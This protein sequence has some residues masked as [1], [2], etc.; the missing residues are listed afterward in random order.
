MPMDSSAAISSPAK[1]ATDDW[2]GAA[3]VP[4][5]AFLM[6]VGFI[7][8]DSVSQYEN[9]LQQAQETLDA[10][11]RIAD[12]AISGPVQQI[13]VE[14]N[15]IRSRRLTTQVRDLPALSTE[16]E[17]QQHFLP[18][19]LA[20][21][22][23][24]EQGI[25]DAHTTTSVIGFDAREREHFKVH[26]ARQGAID[27]LHF[28]QPFVS[29]IGTPVVTVSRPII[30][31]NGKFRGVVAAAISMQHL[32]SLVAPAQP[33]GHS[34]LAVTGRSG[35]MYIHLPYQ[36]ALLGKPVSTLHEE[37]PQFTTKR[38]LASVD[39]DIHVG[40]AREEV[41]Q[42]WYTHAYARLITLLIFAGFLAVLIRH[43]VT[44]RREHQRANARFEA[45][46]NHSSD[47]IVIVGRDGIVRYISPSALTI[48]GFE[49]DFAIG[50]H[51][52]DLSHRNDHAVIDAAWK[53]L[54]ATPNATGRIRYRSR[55]MT[56]GWIMV[57]ASAAA[58]FDTPGIEGVLLMLR[59]VSQQI[60]AERQLQKSEAI[61][62][63]AQAVARIG[64][65]SFDIT[66]NTLRGSD[67]ACH[68]LGVA[69]G[70]IF[71]QESYQLCI[72][73]DD[74][75]MVAHE[76]GEALKG[77]TYD[78]GYRIQVGDEILW[79][80]AKADMLRDE[81]GQ[82][83]DCIGTLQ[84]VT[85]QHEAAVQLTEL[86]EFN[87]KVIAESPVGI[88]VYR[89]DG[90]CILANEALARMIGGDLQTVSQQNFRRLAAWRTLGLLDAAMEALHSGGAV[91]CVA[92]GQSS[93]G[94][95]IA[96]DCEFTCIN[97]HGEK[98]LLQLAYDTSEFHA[99]EQ[100]M[101]EAMNF[102]EEA[103]RAKSEF[104]ANMSHEI[105][106]PMNAILGLAQLAIDEA[107]DPRLIDHLRQ[108]YRS[109]NLLLGI[110]N[111]I[112]DYS[113]IEAGRVHLEQRD[114]NTRDLAANISGMF[115]VA[116]G[117]KSLD[118]T[119]HLAEDVPHRVIGDSL[120]VNQVL[121]NLV[122]NAVKFTEHGS[123][124]VSVVPVADPARSAMLTPD[125]VGSGHVRLKF[126]VS[127]TG[128][129]MDESALGR[130][131][132]PFM[133]ADGSITRRY[134][135]TGL[136]LSISRRLVQMMG[137]DIDVESTPG[138]GST[139]HF[140]LDFAIP[141]NSHTSQHSIQLD[142]P[143][144]F[145]VLV[146]MARPIA[147]A[148]VLLVEDDLINQRVCRS[149]LERTGL[150]VT[151]ANDGEE[152]LACM[153]HESFD[154]VLM[155]LELPLMN[156]LEASSH[157]RANA[158]WK[159]LPVIAVSASVL[160]QDRT[161]CAQA[162]ITDFVMKPLQPMDLISALLRHIK[163]PPSSLAGSEAATAVMPTPTLDMPNA[164]VLRRLLQDLMARVTDNEFIAVA[165]LAELKALIAPMTEQ[166]RTL[167]MRLEAAI[168]RYEYT[169]A[170]AL[171]DELI[172][173]V[174]MPTMTTPDDRA[175]THEETRA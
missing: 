138:R 150:N 16:L 38:H 131:F 44:Q 86:L 162:G 55:H 107:R 109:A 76:W 96:I 151:V 22:T 156:G 158:R 104:L 108:V 45:L 6:F 160:A 77:E 59:D 71:S 165:E 33:A 83:T 154:A 149:L 85:S 30:G 23:I 164:V 49:A 82:I 67:E 139:F 51:Y 64:S 10:Y 130:L 17:R 11:A 101:K 142:E 78:I 72:H 113:K 54:L 119:I 79:V 134:G 88:A 144:T 84:D 62:R 61:L 60:E 174:D 58:H 98:H 173:S 105:R 75:A 19:V 25:V 124:T 63:K 140:T 121:I 129:G 4:L 126:S 20:L 27:E 12:T 110:I 167:V 175:G 133:Q 143:P 41:L 123:I 53:D 7:V 102:A 39:L 128:I 155:D 50:K 127:D 169:M 9:T 122:S 172:H 97:R 1:P 95:P 115:R 171:L 65:W 87:E 100:A 117:E 26:A 166:A 111:D 52:R 153:V 114:F 69:P 73:P 135:G 132:Q 81:N 168:S 48:S 136:G 89:A 21:M 125:T 31:A 91:R 42:A 2:R 147:G 34:T 116:T 112:L 13:D 40:R 93:Y 118:L 57:E 14:L 161:Q 56:R 99:A 8:W 80:Q 90:P 92:K 36:E 68:I 5:V 3:R 120:R 159:N 141:E 74:R 148:R 28:S 37:F 43:T 32:S 146:N 152:A 35:S 46:I 103:S 24:N 47:M 15:E 170:R 70:T 163:H 29:V 94:K 137:G 106:T 18:S 157:I 66:T 145:N